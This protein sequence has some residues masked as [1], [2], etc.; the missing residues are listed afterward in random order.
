MKLIVGLG[1]PGSKYQKT[2]HS[3]GRQI[4]ESLVQ[5]SP[6]HFKKDS[7]LQSHW[8]ELNFNASVFIAAMPDTYM[9]ESGTIVKKLVDHFQIDFKK[10]LLILVDDIAIPFGRLRL[11]PFGED[12]G[13]KG[14]RSI[15]QV[16]NSPE[17]ARMR[18][19]ISPENPITVPLEAFVLQPFDS[20][21]QKALP[22]IMVRSVK[23]CHLWLSEPI[24]K[25]MNLI[26][27]PSSEQPN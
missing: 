25:A 18:V 14:L 26:N 9:N 17:F 23:A 20:E 19:G 3:I 24:E 15:Q 21:E 2:R 16:L 1:N 6:T 12:G 22:E 8:S 10:D 5:E 7:S 4:I 11:R 27:K 13:H